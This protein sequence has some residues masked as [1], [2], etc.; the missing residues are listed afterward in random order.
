MA[1]PEDPIGL[2]F[3]LPEQ[4]GQG[5]RAVGG[6]DAMVDTPDRRRTP[7]WSRGFAVPM[8]QEAMFRVG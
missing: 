1:G 3:L 4:F 6:V 8:E 2:T 7:E 5:I